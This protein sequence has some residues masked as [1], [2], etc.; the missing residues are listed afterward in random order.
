MCF[1]I[2]HI[3]D[4][5]DSTWRQHSTA[6]GQKL[7]SYVEMMKNAIH[8]DE[9]WTVTAANKMCW[10]CV[11]QVLCTC[12]ASVGRLLSTFWIFFESVLFSLSQKPQHLNFHLLLCSFEFSWWTWL[13]PGMKQCQAASWVKPCFIDISSIKHPHPHITSNNSNILNGDASYTHNITVTEKLHKST[14]TQ[15]AYLLQSCQGRQI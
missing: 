14:L 15:S 9:W 11:L 3:S 7:R 8:L 1:I 12:V 13:I 10:G 4:V 5:S 6:C 2:I